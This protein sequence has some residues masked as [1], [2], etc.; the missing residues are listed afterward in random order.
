MLEAN[1]TNISRSFLKMTKVKFI[2]RKLNAL[3]SQS[4][5]PWQKM[6]LSSWS[7]Y[8]KASSLYTILK[9]IRLVLRYSE[10]T[11][12][13]K[14][15][16]VCTTSDLMQS[17]LVKIMVSFQLLKTLRSLIRIHSWLQRVKAQM[18]IKLRLH[19]SQ[20]FIWS[21]LPVDCS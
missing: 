18:L 7:E 20:A 2:Q 5:V 19:L 8:T 13:L 12:L 9:K 11:K 3:T 6:R 10:N 4:V 1:K 21:Q 16:P 14:L 17:L 15:L